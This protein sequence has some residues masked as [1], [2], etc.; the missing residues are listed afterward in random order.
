MSLSTAA[1]LRPSQGGDVADYPTR[2]SQSSAAEKGDV[3]TNRSIF[4]PDAE[5][6]RNLP[7]VDWDITDIA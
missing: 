2:I 4:R 6:D 3:K 5:M 7:G 1:A